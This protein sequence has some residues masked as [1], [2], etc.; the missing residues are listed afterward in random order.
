MRRFAVFANLLLASLL[1]AGC[2]TEMDLANLQDNTLHNTQP[3]SNKFEALQQQV[4]RLEKAE[5]E[6]QRS[7][8]RMTADLDELRL[9]QRKLRG[10]LEELQYH[11]GQAGSGLEDRLAALDQRLRNLERRPGPGVPPVSGPLVPDDEPR[12]LLPGSDFEPEPPI[13][14]AE[15]DVAEPPSTPEPEVVQVEPPTEPEPPSA[16]E[17]EAVPVEPPA[18]PERVVE[19]PVSPPADSPEA[20]RLFQRARDDYQ[21]GNYEVAIILFKQYLRQ[22]PQAAQAGGR[23]VLDRRIPV[24]PKGVQRGHRRL[25]R[26]D[27]AVSAERKSLGGN[28][29]GRPVVRQPGRQT[30]C[31]VLSAT[32]AG[33][34]SQQR[35]GATGHR[36]IETIAALTTRGGRDDGTAGWQSGA[37]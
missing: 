32:G 29:E 23:P 3:P 31:P 37:D 21:Q 4:A 30:E 28:A 19:P 1:L 11:Q 36:K 17:P 13:P 22:H 20:I 10:E 6:R 2:T 26:G 8:I 33:K 24:R 18:E 35:R 25:R 9:E 16:P 12:P 14:P 15:P 7:L 5:A 27:T 34:I